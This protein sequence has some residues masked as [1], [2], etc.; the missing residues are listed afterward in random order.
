MV[1][2]A[3]LACSASATLAPETP[4]DVTEDALPSVV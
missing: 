2:L 4:A 1:V 3:A